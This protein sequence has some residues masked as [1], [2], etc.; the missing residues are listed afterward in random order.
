MSHGEFAHL[1]GLEGWI[2]A[3]AVLQLFGNRELIHERYI[4]LDVHLG[5]GAR[6]RMVDIVGIGGILAWSDEER[7]NGARGA[8]R[9]HNLL[10]KAG[11]LGRWVTVE[12]LGT[13][14]SPEIRVERAVLLIQHEDVLD[15]LLNQAD[16][17]RVR[18]NRFGTFPGAEGLY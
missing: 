15:I 3:R 7:L 4:V 1:L 8:V 11:G 12:S 2:A 10:G 14:E 16:K 5:D 6:M 13:R 9:V 17:L 18:Q